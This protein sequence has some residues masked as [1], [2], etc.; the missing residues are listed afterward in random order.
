MEKRHTHGEKCTVWVW[1]DDLGGVGV[2]EGI[3]KMK[4]RETA[5]DCSMCLSLRPRSET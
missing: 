5:L 4:N 1:D 2:V 3:V